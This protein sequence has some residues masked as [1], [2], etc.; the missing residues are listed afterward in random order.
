VFVKI[1][2]ITR[3]EDAVAAIDAGADAIGLNFVRNSRR[4][5]G[6]ESARAI[7]TVATD[8]IMTIG[9]FRDHEAP[10]ILDITQSLGLGG[11]QIHESTPELTSEVADAVQMVIV[12]VTGDDPSIRSLEDHAA[13]VFMLDGP[14][15]GSGITFDWD[16]VGDLVQRYRILLAG[17]LRSDTVAKAIRRVRP[18]GVDVASGVEASPAE[19]DPYAVARFV[20]E[21]RT[22][23]EP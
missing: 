17:G 6:I 2:G 14:D 3:P 22:A 13:D 15:P 9:V 23:L 20:A 21:A 10:E 16:S 7:L 19:K 5:V 8:Q 11:A 1:C 18:W 4:R 12:A